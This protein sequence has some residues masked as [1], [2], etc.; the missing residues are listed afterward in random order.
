MALPG[1]TFV[2]QRAPYI[3]IARGFTAQLITG[4]ASF[5][6]LPP[7]I[8]EKR[9]LA[10]GGSALRLKQ[11]SQNQDQ[12]GNIGLRMSQK[13][14]GFCILEIRQICGPLGRNHAWGGE[15]DFL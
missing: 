9:A 2:S 12:H 13:S 6:T 8:S 4:Q 5:V 1:K 10:V 14:P 7:I 3:P 15:A 11:N